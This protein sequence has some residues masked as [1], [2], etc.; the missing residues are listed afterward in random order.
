[1]AEKHPYTSG[2]RGGLVQAINQLRS[3]FPPKVT[4]DTLKKLGISPNNE[5][6]IINILRFV[7]I[8]DEQGA[9]TAKAGA[10][11]SKHDDAEFPN[12]AVTAR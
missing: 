2:G 7:G 3:S 9:K 12:R 8:I 4:A 11:F 5:S 6:Y 1:V 10:A